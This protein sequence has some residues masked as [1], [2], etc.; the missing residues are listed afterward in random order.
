MP[1][2]LARLM[3]LAALALLVPLS[4]HANYIWS[5]SGIDAPSASP[6]PMTACKL[7]LTGNSSG[8]SDFRRG[9]T[10]HGPIEES[11]RSV[12]CSYQ[13]LYWGNWI[14]RFIL[15][16]RHGERCD[17]G[18]LYDPNTGQC[19]VPDKDCKAE[20]SDIL[21]RG[22]IA[23][24]VVSNGRTYSLSQAPSSACVDSCGY[25]S[26]DDGRPRY[27]SCYFVG[28]SKVDSF[29]NYILTGTGEPCSGWDWDQPETGD[30][31]NPVDTPD[32]PPSDP[33]DPGC[34]KGWSWSG[35]TCVKTPTDG[36]GGGDKDGEKDDTQPGGGSGGGGGDKDPG[37]DGQ[38]GGTDGDNDK[39]KDPG[40]GTGGGK[41]PN[42]GSSLKP[43]KTGSFDNAN[44][45]WDAKAE[46]ARKAFNDKLKQ[47]M[48]SFKGVFDV[49]LGQG[50]GSLPCDRF[51]VLG[52]TLSLC[53]T[54]YATELAYLRQILLLVASVIAATIV[55]RD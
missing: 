31:L 32:T 22:S 48:N 51:T 50:A 20:T 34:P 26:K 46:Q 41:D 18:T 15:L 27:T 40:T 19:I 21:T 29:C 10:L 14:D 1:L 2:N 53:L 54:D 12:Q 16:T 33:N 44:K 55:L 45:E 30:P 6:N 39:D 37:G 3:V 5:L 35:T 7:A 23:G 52:Q 11:A 36:E 28:G 13:E 17:P 42:K 9:F 25:A 8:T 47:Q 38:D 4:A 49:N 24:V 43:P